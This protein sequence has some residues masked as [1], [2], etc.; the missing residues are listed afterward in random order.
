M[1]WWGLISILL[2]GKQS[3]III[4]R[5]SFIDNQA[6]EHGGAIFQNQTALIDIDTVYFQQNSADLSGGALYTEVGFVYLSK[7]KHIYQWILAW[8]RLISHKKADKL[9]ADERF[10]VSSCSDSK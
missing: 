6:N 3:E 5:T 4:L 8:L 1:R 2:Q 9:H 10:T 7:P